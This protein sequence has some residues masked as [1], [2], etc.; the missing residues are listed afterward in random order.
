MNRLT[1]SELLAIQI[2]AEISEAASVPYLRPYLLNLKIQN[3]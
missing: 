2:I 1:T 3:N